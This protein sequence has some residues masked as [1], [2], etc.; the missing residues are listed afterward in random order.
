M[1]SISD[2]DCKT[3]LSKMK[4]WMESP[5]AFGEERFTGIF[6]RNFFSATFHS[7]HEWNRR[8]TNEKHR[9]IGFIT[10]YGT[11][12]K[13]YCIRLAGMTNPL[14]LLG[15]FSLCI[16]FSI[17]KGIST[18]TLQI[19]LITTAVLAGLTAIS[20]CLTER[21]IR[22]SEIMTNFLVDPSNPYGR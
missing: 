9:A 21:G 4:F 13:I 20:S 14:S 10:P 8:I 5:F 15:I 12:S 17:I 6:L 22:G 19:S 11:G 1:V 18:V 2:M 7:G 16:L 3:Y